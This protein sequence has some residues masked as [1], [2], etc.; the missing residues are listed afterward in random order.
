MP[1]HV[2]C[3]VASDGTK[4]ESTGPRHHPAV[5]SSF[6]GVFGGAD[7]SQVIMLWSVVKEGQMKQ[8][9]QD[10]DSLEDV[11]SSLMECDPQEKLEFSE[12]KH[13]KEQEQC[14]IPWAALVTRPPQHTLV[15]ERMHSGARRYIVLDFGHAVRLTDV[16][17]TMLYINILI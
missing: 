14:N 17:C 1:L 2:T 13:F 8:T 5:V 4:L 16:V 12:E 9:S 15:V 11:E 3:H 6:P 7:P 10:P